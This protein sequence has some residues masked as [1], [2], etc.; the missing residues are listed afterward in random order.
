MLTTFD[1]P[2]KLSLL[3]EKIDEIGGAAQLFLLHE[4]IQALEDHFHRDLASAM[5]S[6]RSTNKA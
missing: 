6:V 2:I 1:D 3:S 5:R 4:V